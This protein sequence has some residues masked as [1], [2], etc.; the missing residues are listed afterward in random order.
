[1]RLFIGI[2]LRETTQQQIFQ[3]LQPFAGMDGYRF[4]KPEN[5]HITLLFLGETEIKPT[6]LIDSLSHVPSQV[7][8][9]EFTLQQLNGFPTNNRASSMGLIVLPK[10]PFLLLKEK[11]IK[12]LSVYGFRMGKAMIPHVTISRMKH[13]VNIQDLQKKWKFTAI[14]QIAESFVLYQSVLQPAGPIYYQ[15]HRFQLKGDDFHG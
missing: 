7:N 4:G 15:V 11:I 13:A 12:A 9:I 2:P 3:M 8:P 10:E 14:K 1:M 5:Y 6:L